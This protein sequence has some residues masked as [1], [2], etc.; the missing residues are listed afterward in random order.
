MP[1]NLTPT[2]PHVVNVKVCNFTLFEHRYEVCDN[3]AD[4]VLPTTQKVKIV[5]ASKSCF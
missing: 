1:L 3:D 5:L 4:T 2:K